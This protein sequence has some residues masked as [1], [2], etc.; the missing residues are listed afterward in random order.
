MYETIEVK[1]N[2]TSIRGHWFKLI[3]SMINLGLILHTMIYFADINIF[4][5]C[6]YILMYI[7]CPQIK[8]RIKIVFIFI[9]IYKSNE[10]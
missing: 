3:F 7:S 8:S 2:T 4:Y 9:T 10:G 5:C 6:N 1:V